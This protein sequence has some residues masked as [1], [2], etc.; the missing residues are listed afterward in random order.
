[1]LNEDKFFENN[2]LHKIEDWLTWKFLHE[3]HADENCPV[4]HYCSIQAMKSIIEDGKMRFTDI[5]YLNDLQEFTYVQEAYREV[6][7]DEESEF[8]KTFIEL[9]NSEE[10]FSKID[11]FG[12]NY[13]ISPSKDSSM[14]MRE[15]LCRVFVCCF[16]LKRDE[17]MMWNYYG[18]R[19]AGCNIE[20]DLLDPSVSSFQG[21]DIKRSNVIY[22]EE[23]HSSIKELLYLAHKIWK[24]SGNEDFIKR[25]IVMQLNALRIFLKNAA[26]KN[27]REYRIALLV[28]EAEMDDVG[29]K[30][31]V[32]GNMMIPYIEMELGDIEA[33]IQG[34]T[35]GPYARNELNK[36]SVSDLLRMNNLKD[37]P[38]H[39]SQVPM[40]NYLG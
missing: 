12:K 9:I 30:F 8:D 16:S 36:S 39:F 4:Y 26:F 3:N 1:M 10:I 27:E 33:E 40:R 37:V 34:I 11:G 18:G 21:M 23:S 13:M 35:L 22:G 15:E 19:N 38:I 14:Q 25:F 32:R 31:F 7:L 29:V 6:C 20:V 28:P 17:L 2:A 24:K 5:R